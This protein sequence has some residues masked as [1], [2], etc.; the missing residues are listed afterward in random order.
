MIYTPG[1]NRNMMLIFETFIEYFINYGNDHFEK[2]K[3]KLDWYKV[4]ENLFIYN[5][6]YEY[7]EWDILMNNKD[8]SE[9]DIVKYTNELCDKIVNNGERIDL[10]FIFKDDNNS[11]VNDIDERKQESDLLK[12]NSKK[13][14]KCKHFLDNVYFLD[15]CIG[16]EI[17]LNSIR[18]EF[19]D[20]PEDIKKF[21]Y[22]IHK[23]N[24]LKRDKIITELMKDDTYPFDIEVRL[25]KKFEENNIPKHFY[26]Q[27]KN[28]KVDRN[29]ILKPLECD[30][31]CPYFEESDIGLN[32]FLNKYY[33]VE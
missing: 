3:Y 16:I 31:P 26:F 33:E 11:I 10:I 5:S 28:E 32:E 6:Y 29:W 18:R 15:T 17:S 27:V 9:D 14:Y 21:Y 8:I 13:C 23:Y 1:L 7:K 2:D 30:K 4:Y 24:C 25:N 22:I 12:F 19:K 20:K